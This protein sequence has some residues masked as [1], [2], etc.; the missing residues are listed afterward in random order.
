MS[1]AAFTNRYRNRSLFLDCKASLLGNTFLGNLTET[2][3]EK[4]CQRWDN[5]TK[6]YHKITANN[7]PEKSLEA[8]GNNCR[9]PDDDPIGPWCYT[10]DP[11]TPWEYCNV[12]LCKGSDQL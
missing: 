5:V 9:N 4:T 12:P 3:S 8:A 6:N 7:L 10:T 2:R 11:D 1:L